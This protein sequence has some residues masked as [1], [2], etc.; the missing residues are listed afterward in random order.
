MNAKKYER[1]REMILDYQDAFERQRPEHDFLQR[2]RKTVAAA[3]AAFNQCETAIMDQMETASLL[4]FI[5]G[6][7]FAMDVM[8]L[9]GNEKNAELL[10]SLIGSISENDEE[11]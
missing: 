2:H 8:N 6:I 7:Q 10:Q 4:G 5:E 3:N 1:I 11:E 9:S